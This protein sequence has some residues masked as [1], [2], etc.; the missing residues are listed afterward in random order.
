MPKG[1]D[2]LF[3]ATSCSSAGWAGLC[4]VMGPTPVHAKHLPSNL[5]QPL[6]DHNVF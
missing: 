1:F 2:Y 3:D 6:D 5:S 4:H